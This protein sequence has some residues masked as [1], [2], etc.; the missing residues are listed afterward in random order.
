LSLQQQAPVEASYSRKSQRLSLRRLREHTTGYLFILP[1]SLFF[2]V[3]TLYPAVEAIRMSFYEFRVSGAVFTGLAN[4]V[5][6]FKDEK[7]VKALSNTFLYVVYI[8]PA[9]IVFALIVAASIYAYSERWTGFFRAIFY[10]PTVTSAVAISLVWGWIF[11]PGSEALAN[12]ILISLGL[13]PSIWFA[14][15]ELSMVMIVLVIL[16]VSVGQ[17]IVL[18]TAAMGS[19]SSD[20][21]EASLVDGATKLQQFMKITI[22]LLMPTTLYCVVITTINAFQTFIFIHLLTSG[23]PDNRTTSIIYQLYVEAFGNNRFG[24]AS[25]M[26]IVLF[27]IVGLVAVFQFRSMTSKVE[28]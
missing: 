2:I 13:E 14:D 22:P 4:Y 3:F 1:I 6:I 23:G 16:T 12:R 5:E 7:F 8:V 9:T 17:P 25:A 15:A 26:G 21:Y 20:Y 28:Y 10:L 18:Y 27:A 24:T 19:I 11:N